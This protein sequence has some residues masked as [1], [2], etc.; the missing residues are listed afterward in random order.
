MV[1][2]G[3]LWVYRAAYRWHRWP[4][5]ASVRSSYHTRPAHVHEIHHHHRPQA[6]ER[7]GTAGGSGSSG[8]VNYHLRILNHQKTE[9]T[10]RLGTFVNA[11]FVLFRLAD[12]CGVRLELAGVAER[13]AAVETVDV[14]V[15]AAPVGVE[16]GFCYYIIAAFGTISVFRQSWRY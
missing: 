11:L 6:A 2:E 1:V 10:N 8:P 15:A 7:S 12:A 14:G 4:T 3:I 13:L 16:F 5:P 9:N